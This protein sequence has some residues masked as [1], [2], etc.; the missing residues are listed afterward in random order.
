L[1]LQA[2]FSGLL[3][4]FV[5]AHF[6]HHLLTALPIPL[7]P[8]IRSHFTLDYTRSG[9]VISA[10]TLAYGF[11]QL[12]SGWL[13]DRVGPRIIMTLG[14]C[15][16]AL[17]GLLVGLSH[18]YMTL[19]VFLVLMGMLGGGYHPA[20][21][22]LI[23]SSIDSKNLGRALGLHLIGGSSSYFLSP[24]IAAAIA[25]VWGW[26]GSFITLS[27]PTAVFGIILYVLLGQH[28]VGKKAIQKETRA[29]KE[30]TPK[31]GSA[32]PLLYFLF[33]SIFTHAVLNSTISFIPLFLVDHFEIPKETA[34]ALL[35]LVYSAGLWAAPLGG[36]LSD[37]LGRI[38]VILFICLLTGPVIYLLNV[39]PYRWG[40]I[41][42]LISV[43]VALY[44]RM[45]VAEAYIVSQT[46]EHHRSTILGIYFFGSIEGGGVLTP[47]MGYL[48]DQLGFYLSFTMAGAAVVVVTLICSFWLWDYRD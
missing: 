12:P 6:G 3:P 13:A 24:L 37:R 25:T 16:V 5:L 17:A 35:A 32:R 1:D 33:L 30:E 23:S 34:A 18:T 20:V 2:L 43:G 8:M 19:I 42:L 28:L 14:I 47:V 36:H 41:T 4:L 15:G 39:A 27:V 46:A 9:F 10:F 26:R 38:P 29:G 40:I 31:S 22:P 11:G 48:I 21:P 45:A 7:L 44:V